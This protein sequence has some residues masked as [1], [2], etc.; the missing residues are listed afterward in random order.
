MFVRDAE[1]RP[2]PWGTQLYEELRETPCK[3]RRGRPRRIKLTLKEWLLAL[4]PWERARAWNRHATAIAIIHYY[5]FS[6][7][8]QRIMWR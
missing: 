5:G 8:S 4:P 3:R 6:L 2:V 7:L 1:G